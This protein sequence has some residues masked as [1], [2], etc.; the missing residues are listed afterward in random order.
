MVKPTVALVPWDPNSETHIQRMVDQRLACGWHAPIVATDWKKAHIEGLK[1]LYWIVF[2][3]QEPYREPFLKKHIKAYPK[4]AE[5]L[6]DTCETLLG[7]PRIPTRAKFLPVG[8]IALDRRDVHAAETTNLD[9]PRSDSYWIKSLYASYVLQGIGLGRATMDIAERHA[10]EAPLNAKY[11]LLDTVHHEDQSNENY[12]MATY[13]GTFKVPTQ[14]WYERRGYR[15]IGTV[16]NLYKDPDVNGKVWPVR[17]VF[18]QKE[19]V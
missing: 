6:A 16:P 15:L 13:G 12:A 18:L 19:V 8:H 9:I 7:K 10:T 4:E 17:T 14:A 2:P 1:C 5:E 3:E 11:L